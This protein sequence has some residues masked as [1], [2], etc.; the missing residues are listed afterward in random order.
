MSQAGGEVRPGDHVVRVDRV[1]LRDWDRR[2]EDEGQREQ[3]PADAALNAASLDRHWCFPLLLMDRSCTP[4][5]NAGTRDASRYRPKVHLVMRTGRV[6][7]RGTA[8]GS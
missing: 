5:R 1:G 7:A 6:G 4:P 2:E 8:P 3:C